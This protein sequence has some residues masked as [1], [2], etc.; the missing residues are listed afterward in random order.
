MLVP[1]YWCRMLLQFPKISIRKENRLPNHKA[2]KAQN[3]CFLLPGGENIH[4]QCI[5]ISVERII[6]RQAYN[7]HQDSSTILSHINNFPVTILVATNYKYGN[8]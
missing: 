1:K 7:T 8:R 3:Q 4:I 5:T 6:I 2:R